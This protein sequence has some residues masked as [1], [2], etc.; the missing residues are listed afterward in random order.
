MT[1]TRYDSERDRV[2]QSDTADESV[3]GT[4]CP[5]CG[6]QVI[7]DEGRGEA[8][9]EACGLVIDE[10]TI[11]RGPEWRA[12]D[13]ADRDE[14]SRVG[15]PMTELMHDKGLSTTIGWQD[16]DAYGSALSER[17]RARIQRL[18]TWDE[19][20][21]TKDAQ[22]RNLKQAFGEIDRMASALDL[23]EPVRETGGALYR[24]A[25]EADLL[26][27]RSIEGMATAALYAATRQHGAPRRVT[28]FADVSRVSQ[29]RIE[30]AYRYLKNE[31][32]LAIEPEDPAKYVPQFASAL[33]LSDEVER[34]ATDLLAVAKRANRHSGKSPAG[35]AAAAVYAAATLTNE[36]TT[37]ADVSAVADVSRVTIRDRYQELLDV[38]ADQES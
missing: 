2:G 17:K 23:S 30:R 13:D 37:Q 21:R 12:F 34:R 22:E 18:R 14:K 9:C 26:P 3:A 6:G 31:L 10:A 35:L 8:T 11:D 1:Q 36:S 27:G 33:E 24:A 19:R 20:F 16:K 25:V 28:E 15:A 38:Y 7:Q 32:G 29:K 5:E 4:T